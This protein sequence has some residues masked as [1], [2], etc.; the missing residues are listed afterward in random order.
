MSTGTFC[1][2]GHLLQVSSTSF[3]SL[4]L[5]KIFHDFI[6]VYSP[7]AGADSPQGQNFDGNRKALT[8]YPF[9][10][11]FKEISLKSDFIHDLGHHFLFFWFTK[12][13]YPNFSKTGI[14]IKLLLLIIFFI[15]FADPGVL[16]MQ[17]KKKKKKEDLF[18]ALIFVKKRIS[19]KCGI[20]IIAFTVF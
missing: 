16:V 11:N 8:L 14:K 4:I 12:S 2:F 17:K 18:P 20:C 1:H 19:S 6:H 9:V 3:W 13:A 10:A 5:Y 15:F 7:G